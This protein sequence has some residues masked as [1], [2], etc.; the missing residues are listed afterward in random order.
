MIGV[1]RAA[2]PWKSLMRVP[3]YERMALGSYSS[4]Y[5]PYRL[6]EATKARRIYPF[7]ERLCGRC[8]DGAFKPGDELRRY[9]ALSPAT[10]SV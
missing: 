4:L 2:G 10:Y 7:G 5:G 8:N 9:A 1:M 3:S 6:A